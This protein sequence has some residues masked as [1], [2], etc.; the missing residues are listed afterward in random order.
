MSTVFVYEIAAVNAAV[1]RMKPGDPK[2]IYAIPFYLVIGEPGAGRSTA[3]RA[4]Q[5]TWPE[6][7]GRVNTGLP[8]QYCTYWM[9]QEAVFIEP[10]KQVVGPERDPPALGM[11]CNELKTARPREALDGVLL[12]MNV[13]EFADL[14]ESG[15]ER[16]SRNMRAYLV[17]VVRGLDADIPVYI[18]VSGYDRLWGFADVFQWNKDRMREDPWGFVM[19][20]DVLTSDSKE[21]LDEELAGLGAR[22]EAFCLAK[23]SSDDPQDQRARA[24]QHLS[25]SRLVMEKLRQILHV[26]AAGNA[27]ERAP[28]LRALTIGTAT[29][30]TGDKL[31]AS[32]A[33]FYSMGYSPPGGPPQTRP[34]GLPMHQF[35]QMVVIPDK[36][37][38]PTRTRWRD[39]KLLVISFVVGGALVLITIIVAIV[40]ATQSS[41]P[42]GTGRGPQR[43]G[44]I[45]DVRGAEVA[46]IAGVSG[47]AGG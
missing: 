43:V 37:L 18:V 40:F 8:Q 25:E 9:A 41:R 14:D 1:Q 34:G 44:A 4:M 38:V 10:Q 33:R 24:Y 7:D 23:L 20:G 2:G 42:G 47:A 32:V 45:D 35:M 16:Y 36:D 11:L 6:G 27:Y 3:L 29:P 19:P 12:V 39:D 15:L 28:W 21:K 26:L 46:M 31:R 13:G 30:G 5:L 17:E 22:L